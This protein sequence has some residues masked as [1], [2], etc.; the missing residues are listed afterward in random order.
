MSL[1]ECEHCKGTRL[2]CPSC[3]HPRR[4]GAPH[5]QCRPHK[6]CSAHTETFRRCDCCREKL[7]E[8]GSF[9]FGDIYL[10]V[11]NLCHAIAATEMAKARV[12]I[13]DRILELR[14]GTGPAL[15]SGHG[16]TRGSETTPPR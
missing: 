12:V 10:D 14:T 13:V 6:R 5:R 11:C 15:Q 7:E 9:A 1:H 4:Y 2:V 8:Y 3:N 16:P